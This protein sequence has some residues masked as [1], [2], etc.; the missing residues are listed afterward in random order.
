MNKVA[1]EGQV[2]VCGA[3]GKRSK[4]RYGYQKID[5]W[6][7]ESCVIYSFLCYESHLLFHPT[8]Y[9]REVLDG[10]VVEEGDQI[11]IKPN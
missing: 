2:Y 8:G 1:P 11:E 5:Q 7:D 10:G 9:V 6:W 4:D 3:C